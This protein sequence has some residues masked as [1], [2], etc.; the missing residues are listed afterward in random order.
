M[1]TTFSIYLV[2][3]MLLS[4]GAALCY[5]ELYFQR[6]RA[7]WPFLWVSWSL[8]S[9]DG[10]IISFGTHVGCIFVWCFIAMMR[11]GHRI[12]ICWLVFIMETYSSSFPWILQHARIYCLTHSCPLMETFLHHHSFIID[13][14]P[15]WR[16]IVYLSR[17]LLGYFWKCFLTSSFFYYC[18]NFSWS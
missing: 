4:Y 14:G 7:A 13:G 10:S 2:A 5:V 11:E 15:S 17:L 1:F 9:Y 18:W 8:T 6:L 3:W 12:H 16:L